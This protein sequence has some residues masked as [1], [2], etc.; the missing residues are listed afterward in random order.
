MVC[1]EAIVKLIVFSVNT[2]T[3]LGI[4]ATGILYKLH[5]SNVTSVIP[6]DY[7]DIEIAPTL[8]I[9]IGSIIFII[10]FLGCFGTVRESTCL[11]NW[12]R[13]AYSE[14]KMEASIPCQTFIM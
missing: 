3:G 5:F 12:V 8:S 10:A 6:A 2:L 1:G 9:I 4:L 11:L 14:K 13:T 7:Q